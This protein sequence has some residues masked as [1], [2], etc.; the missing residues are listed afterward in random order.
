MNDPNQPYLTNLKERIE[1]RRRWEVMIP[2]ICYDEILAAIN[3]L[4]DEN[5]ELRQ[6]IE[7]MKDGE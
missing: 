6:E 5:A 3:N 2:S 7:K 4:Q 1:K